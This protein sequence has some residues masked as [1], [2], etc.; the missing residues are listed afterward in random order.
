M[1]KFLR[2]AEKAGIEALDQAISTVSDRI[3]NYPEKARS[4]A[5]QLLDEFEAKLPE[6]E[7]DL[8]F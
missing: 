1:R 4:L 5:K 3:T 7:D 8:P 6:P 2:K